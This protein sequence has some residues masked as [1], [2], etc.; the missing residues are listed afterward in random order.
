VDN[1]SGCNFAFVVTILIEEAMHQQLFQ[2][3]IFESAVFFELD[4]FFG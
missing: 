1:G 4:L 2:V 3:F